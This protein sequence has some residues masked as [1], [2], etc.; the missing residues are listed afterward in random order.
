MISQ[1]T[2]D[3]VYEV[4]YHRPFLVKIIN[5]LFLHTFFEGIGPVA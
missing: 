5:S 1:K 2:E 4:V 3:M